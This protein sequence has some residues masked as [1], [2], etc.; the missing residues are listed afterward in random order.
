ME[1]KT[2]KQIAINEEVKRPFRNEAINARNQGG[3]T[4]P[5]WEPFNPIIPAP[6]ERPSTGAKSK[7]PLQTSREGEIRK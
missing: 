5:K 7:T 2:Q 6:A 4:V 3:E 1:K